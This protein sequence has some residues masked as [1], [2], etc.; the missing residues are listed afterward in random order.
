MR[1]E[2]R[3]KQGG[4][5]GGQGGSGRI[6]KTLAVREKRGGRVCDDTWVWLKD[7]DR[8]RGSS[9]FPRKERVYDGKRSSRS[10]FPMC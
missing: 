1:Q 3:E 6:N 10:S 9:H 8:C 5:E 4:L 2:E 7:P